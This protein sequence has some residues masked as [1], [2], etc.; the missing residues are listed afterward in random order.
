MKCA[1]VFRHTESLSW[2]E[3]SSCRR[4]SKSI[5][6]VQK[7][8][9]V[10]PTCLNWIEESVEIQFLNFHYSNFNNEL[11]KFKN[12]KF[13]KIKR[14]SEEDGVNGIK[15]TF[16]LF[17]CYWYKFGDFEEISFLTFCYTTNYYWTKC[18]WLPFARIYSLRI[19]AKNAEIL[20]CCK[21]RS[22]IA[23]TGRQPANTEHKCSL[24]HE[25][26]NKNQIKGFE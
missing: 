8:I 2:S 24:Q 21:Q 11:I 23:A 22:E 3:K 16:R 20:C 14:F 6:E 4:I 1:S 17:D 7:L 26:K 18:L 15:W 5:L 25:I 10:P 13:I 9:F 12:I 19:R